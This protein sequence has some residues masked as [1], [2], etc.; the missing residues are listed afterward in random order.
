[1]ASEKIYLRLLQSIETTVSAALLTHIESLFSTKC[2]INSTPLNIGFALVAER[3]QYNSTSIL[4]HLKRTIPDDA[5]ALLGIVD[6]D[7]YA[8]GLNFVFGEAEVGG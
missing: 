6:D 4:A 3:G 1:M 5:R 2:D 8:S 7:L